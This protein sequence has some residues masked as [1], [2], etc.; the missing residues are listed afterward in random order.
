MEKNS[1]KVAFVQ[2]IG[3]GEYETETLWC[4]IDG[5]NFIVDNIPIIA[6]RISLGDTIK[7]EYDE[8]EKRYYFDDFIAV[9][10]NTTVRVYVDDEKDI[11]GARKWLSEH[12]CESEVLLARNI[13]AIN[14]PKEV[15]YKPIKEYLDKGEKN[16]IWTYEESCLMHA[17]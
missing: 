3:D 5:D 17:Y 8:D 4:D 9:S 10:G 2:E 1:V 11:E 12:K 15:E 6:K 14:I 16:N 13:I 7:A